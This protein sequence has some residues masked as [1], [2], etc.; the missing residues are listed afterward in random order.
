MLAFLQQSLHKYILYFA[1][2]A[3]EIKP[4]KLVPNGR[5]RAPWS[6]RYTT[7][8]RLQSAQNLEGAF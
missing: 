6:S 1:E 4:L 2:P 8:A 7:M 5:V 3:R